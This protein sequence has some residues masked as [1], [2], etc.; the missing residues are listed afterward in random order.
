[1]RVYKEEIEI[2]R[3][4]GN[5]VS[6]FLQRV[7]TNDFR[8]FENNTV[9]RTVFTTDKGRIVDLVTVLRVN[10]EYIL[11]CSVNRESLVKDFLNKYIVTEDINIKSD[12]CVKYTMMPEF[13]LDYKFM[14]GNNVVED[15]IFYID[16]Y[17]F[18][19]TVVLV[20]NQSSEFIITLLENTFQINDFDFKCIAIDKGFLYDSN[21]LNEDINPLEC[22]LKEYVSFN[23]G[24]YIGQEV[25]ARMDTQNKV[26]K[27]MLKLNAEFE[28]NTGYKIYF[29]EAGIETECGF[30]SS[31]GK[32]T[33]DN[34]AIGFIREINLKDEYNYYINKNVNYVILINKFKY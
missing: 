33:F 3:L 6:D 20:F 31:I 23:K 18:R 5:D 26:P 14:S 7:S 32:S 8:K 12:S 17:R 19:K 2:L 21:E 1:M 25:I 29:S 22:G 9:L 15:N 4:S 11:V 28:F 24:C 16:D 27:V 10:D 30:I 13:E 34:T